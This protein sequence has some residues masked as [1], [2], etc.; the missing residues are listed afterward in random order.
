MDKS[1]SGPIVHPL[2]EQNYRVILVDYD[3]CPNL[4]LKQLTQQ[5]TNFYKWLK[6]YADETRAPK[7]SICGHSAGAHLAL[8]IF[9]NEFVRPMY[10]LGLVDHVFLISG[11]YDLRELWSYKSC[12][13]NNVLALNDDLAHELSPICWTYDKELIGQYQR[14]NLKMHVIVAEHDSEAFKLQSQNYYKKLADLNLN[15]S[16]TV[17][18]SYDHFNIIEECSD[19]DSPISRYMQRAMGIY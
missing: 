14:Q 15:V 5:I 3:V 16:Y 6:S 8:Q 12:N 17:F 18:E 9:D 19:R 4:T 7:I 11:L 13:P 1:S 2:V 10:R